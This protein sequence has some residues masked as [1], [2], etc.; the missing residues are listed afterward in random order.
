[1]T[2][3]LLALVLTAASLSSRALAQQEPPPEAMQLFAD[4]RDAYLDGRYQDA[5]VALE[6]ALQL[7]PGSPTLLW[8]LSRVYELM[9]NLDRAIDYADRYLTLLPPEATNE[10][11]TTEE[12]LARLRGARDWLALRQQAER[13]ERQELRQLGTRT[14]VQDRGVADGLF[15]GTLAAAIAVAIG[16]GVVGA[17]S[18]QSRNAARDV[19]LDARGVPEAELDNVVA[20]ATASRQDHEDRARRRGITADVLLGVSV[21]TLAAAVLLYFRRS[22][23]YELEAERTDVALGVDRDRLSLQLRST[24]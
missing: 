11:Q 18:L 4:G 16:G 19:Q 23:T 24:F 12:T 15:F 17:L 6:H 13:G 8:N 22:T 21:A 1:M 2:R 3:L 9:G 7:D 20:A 14:V 5:A 10:R